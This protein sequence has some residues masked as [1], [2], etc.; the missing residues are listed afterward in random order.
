[1]FALSTEV[2]SLARV[3]CQFESD[4]EQASDLDL[5][6]DQRVDRLTPVAALRALARLAEID[7]PG[8]LADHDQV[9]PETIDRSTARRD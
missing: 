5:V 9:D 1:M 4:A 2:S 7:A 3:A 8:Q 6:V